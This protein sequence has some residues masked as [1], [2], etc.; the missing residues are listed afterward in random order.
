MYSV[1]ISGLRGVRVQSLCL[2]GTSGFS[3]K[4]LGFRKKVPGYGEDFC[5]IF[6]GFQVESVKG[7]RGFRVW[8]LGFSSWVS[9]SYP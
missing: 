5:K 7:F 8:V 9:D 2:R 3:F 1:R 6:A 4:G